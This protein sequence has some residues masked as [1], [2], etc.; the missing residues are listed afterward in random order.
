M[1]R[2]S[3]RRTD[4]SSR[5]VLT[6]MVCVCVCERERDLETST[7]RRPR[8]E[9][10]C[11]AT[12]RNQPE[13]DGSR[14]PPSSTEVKNEWSYTSVPPYA[15]MAWTVTLP[16]TFFVNEYIHFVRKSEDFVPAV[17]SEDHMWAVKFEMDVFLRVVGL[18]ICV[19]YK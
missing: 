18:K 12:K 4:L 10:G 8:P 19:C 5:G 7:L 6:S 16:C 1:W 17:V 3:L 2:S 11:C 13:R 9:W 14:S 15:F